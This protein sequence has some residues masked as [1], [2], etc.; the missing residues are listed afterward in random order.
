MIEKQKDTDKARHRD[1]ETKRYRDSWRQR[2]TKRQRNDE[3]MALTLF[4][5]SRRKRSSCA[6]TPMLRKE[7]MQYS[8][9]AALSMNMHVSMQVVISLSAQNSSLSN[10]GRSP[11]QAGKPKLAMEPKLAA[12]R[13]LRQSRSSQWSRSS[14]QAE[15]CAKA[16]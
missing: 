6:Q 1:I 10:Q 12:S 8:M 3:A 9:H 14:L 5:T 7:R 2:A 11:L 16:N 4:A 15:A 13:S